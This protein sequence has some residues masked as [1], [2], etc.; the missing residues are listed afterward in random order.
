MTKEVA[1]KLM[2]AYGYKMV[3]EAGNDSWLGFAKDMHGIRL[4][5]KVE[6]VQEAVTLT[7]GVL[8]MMCELSCKKF[9]INSERFADF[10]NVLYLYAKICS[11]IDSL[12]DAE[13]IIKSA[14]GEA[15]VNI[16]EDEGTT[17]ETNTLENRVA[18]FKK[19]VIEVA[20][21]NGYTPEMT[22]AFF[23]Y[24]SEVS[25]GGKK[26]R[27]EIMK[28]KKGTFNIAGRLVTWRENDKTFKPSFQST[29]EKVAAQ[30]NKELKQ[31]PK[32]INTKELF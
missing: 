8:K 12:V 10:E 21:D 6:L 3:S 1:I 32:T 31:K 2:D 24:W 20:K 30:Q 14:F 26:M 16:K 4:S 13:G 29:K 15:S 18:A 17:E 25:D 5:A 23:K 28:S 7:G 27:W 11:Q 22:K 9:D 19:K